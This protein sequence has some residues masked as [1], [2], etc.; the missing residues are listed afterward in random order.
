MTNREEFRRFLSVLKL[1]V[2]PFDNFAF[3]LCRDRFGINRNEYADLR[4]AAVAGE[5]S[6]FAKWMERADGQ[7]AE[8]YSAHIPSTAAELVF[9]AAVLLWG[10]LSEDIPAFLYRIP[11]IQSMT[12]SDFLEWLATYDVSDEIAEN[13][14]NLQLMTIHA[15]KGLEWPTVVIAGLNEGLLP[16][17]QA[18]AADDLEAE[19]RLAYVAMTRARDLLVLTVRPEETVTERGYVYRNPLSRFVHEA[20]P[21]EAPAQAAAA[22]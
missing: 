4:L 2:N 6:H 14:A 17:K 11:G 12:V 19:R 7:W 16:S 5:R 15:A 22:G 13:E 21:E 10:D 8:F 20:L 1:L 9:S 18:I 3:M